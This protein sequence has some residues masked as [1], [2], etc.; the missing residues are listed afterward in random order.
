MYKGNCNICNCEILKTDFNYHYSIFS[1]SNND[2]LA[3][4]D[5]NVHKH[6]FTENNKFN[7]HK[8]LKKHN[9]DVI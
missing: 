3:K 2:L 5:V 6:A 4:K 9:W 1:F 8:A 7:F